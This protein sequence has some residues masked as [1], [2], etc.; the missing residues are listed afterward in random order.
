MD[1][2]KYFIKILLDNKINMQ[3]T[4]GYNSWLNGKIERTH[5]TLIN[6]VNSSL[7][8]SGNRTD[9]WC[10]E[11]ENKKEIYN[12]LLHLDINEQP[13]IPM[14]WTYNKYSLF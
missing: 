2:S 5:Q 3:T 4:G 1:R 12:I 14:L 6:M 7:C 11:F 10:Y 13:H 8:Y 9:K